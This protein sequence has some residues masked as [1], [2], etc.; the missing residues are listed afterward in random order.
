MNKRSVFAVV[1]VA[2]LSAYAVSSGVTAGGRSSSK[3][4]KA[5]AERSG[6]N[7]S[8]GK[9]SVDGLAS[10]VRALRAELTQVRTELL[11]TR[12]NVQA[13]ARPQPAMDAPA[14]Q[15][16]QALDMAALRAGFDA[17]FEA[18]A[19]DWA[20]A[21]QKQREI[22][23]AFDKQLRSGAHLEKVECRASMCRAHMRFDSSEARQAFLD[24]GI[25]APPF[26]QASF[27]Q[28]NYE[29]EQVTLFLAREG[30]ALPSFEPDLAP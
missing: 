27:Y 19:S 21:N 8:A 13:A 14:V 2:G 9:G 16:Q 5:Q 24:D 26:D 29:T 7:P 15:Q 6:G 18:Q 28:T 4:A 10:Q 23:S 30:H 1:V 3:Q 17:A 25:G 22:A 11:A 20:W 12:A